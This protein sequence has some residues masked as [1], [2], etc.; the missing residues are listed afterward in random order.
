MIKKISNFIS[1][2][3]LLSILIFLLLAGGLY[4]I[5]S[6][7][8]NTQAGTRYVFA[9]ATKDT[10]II[11]VSGSGQVSASDQQDVKSKATGQVVYVGAEK[12]QKIQ[13]GALLLQLDTKDALQDIEDARQ[14]LEKVRLELEKM[15]GMTTDEGTIRGTKEKAADALQKSFED[16]FDDVANVYSG[17]STLANLKDILFAYN[18]NPNQSNIVYYGDAVKIYDEKIITSR[19]DAYNKYNLADKTYTAAFANYKAANRY[20]D[21]AVIE[22]LIDQTKDAVRKTSDAITAANN[23]IKFYQD[24]LVA[25]NLTPQTLSTTHLSQLTTYA[26]RADSQISSMISAKNTIEASREA[27]IEAGFDLTDKAD[28]VKNAEISLADAR[29]KLADYYVYSPFSGT[30]AEISVEKGDNISANSA[31]M[32]LVT[33]ERIAEISLNEVD[34]AKVKTGQKTSLTFDAIPDLTLTGKVLDIDTIGTVSQGVVTYGA[35]ISL[36]AQDERV[37]PGMSVSA[38]IIVQAKQDVIAIP[39]SAIKSDG[40]GQYVQ[41]MNG[42]TLGTKT[43]EIGISNDTM[44]EITSGLV[45]GDK[46]VSQII[47][48]DNASTQSNQNRS[49]GGFGVPVITGGGR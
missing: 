41:I 27:L 30:V 39:S 45:E 7:N 2:H 21:P 32:T 10:L 11:S 46:F 20:S 42:E 18:Y 44:T 22:S 35:K 15:Q 37:K 12:D 13:K 9:Q 49:T 1:G 43:V 26:Q 34:A 23:L 24:I 17:T 47:S 5:Y 33:E 16:G 3:K 14:N 48:Q 29:D 8:K 19:D 6:K 31:I 4:A 38:S 25:K 36:D 28:Q 40:Q